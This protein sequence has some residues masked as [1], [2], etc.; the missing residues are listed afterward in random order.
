MRSWKEICR[1][2]IVQVSN[3]T[4]NL[5]NLSGTFKSYRKSVM[6]YDH[7]VKMEGN[8]ENHHVLNDLP[9]KRALWGV[10]KGSNAKN[11][12]WNIVFPTWS[13]LTL[14]WRW[15]FRRS[16]CLASKLCYDRICWISD[17][18]K[19]AI[20][21]AISKQNCI[22][23]LC[24]NCGCTNVLIL[25]WDVQKLFRIMIQSFFEHFQKVWKTVL[26]WLELGSCWIIFR[27]RATS[28][29]FISR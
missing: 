17:F 25:L 28:S 9:L 12:Y 19:W 26:S 27:S 11:S 6:K 10:K 29:K 18:W 3:N 14:R 5:Q 23:P 1:E 15:W 22:L 20:L 8:Q 13:L 2:S 16:R 24:R 21:K 7:W 4:F